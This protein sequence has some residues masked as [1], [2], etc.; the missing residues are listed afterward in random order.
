MI[1]SIKDPS[2]L[3]LHNLWY[4]YVK[5]Y[6]TCLTVKNMEHVTLAKNSQKYFLCLQTFPYVTVKFPVCQK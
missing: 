2:A 5:T 3:F 6:L 4:I 1:S